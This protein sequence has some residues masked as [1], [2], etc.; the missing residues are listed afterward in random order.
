MVVS[1]SLCYCIL[2]VFCCYV[3]MGVS[4]SLC[5][6]ILDVFC[7]YVIIVVSYSLCY[8]Y[9]FSSN[10]MAVFFA[11]L[12]FYFMKS[13]NIQVDGTIAVNINIAMS[14]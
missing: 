4:Y 11:N 1:Y 2:D 9:I 6:C 13:A 3:I 8:F 10:Q 7:C 5:Y 12:N 14:V